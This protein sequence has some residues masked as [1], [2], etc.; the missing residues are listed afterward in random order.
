MTRL[1]P[2]D[3]APPFTLL[4]ADESPVSLADF[5]GGAVVVY[6]YP[7]AMTPGCAI[8]A[9]DFESA[10][11][12]LAAAGYHLLGVS[13]DDPAK[14]TRFRDRDSLKF[15]LL[16]DPDKA[17]AVAYGAFGT[18]VLYGRSIE[19]VIRSTFVVDVDEGGAG[20]VRI[21]LYNVRAKGHVDR[22][23]EELGL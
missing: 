19:G 14:L 23:R 10:R 2:N 21:A 16:S 13:P 3:A 1:T 6:F 8:E 20:T 12:E 22:L 17:V 9:A 7:A 11:P 5:A 18:K 4:D 15:T